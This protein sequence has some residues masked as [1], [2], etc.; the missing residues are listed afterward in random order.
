[1]SYIILRGHCCD[2]IVLN[3]LD[4]IE[5][6]ID[7][8]KDSLCDKLECVF[9]KFPKEQ[10]TVELEKHPLLGNGYVTRNSGVTVGSVVFCEVCAEAI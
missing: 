10:R 9:N 5:D 4:L 3:V 8:M 7:D 2:I 1:M 6:K